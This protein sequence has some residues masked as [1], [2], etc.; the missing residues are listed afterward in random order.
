MGQ[1]VG[2]ERVRRWLTDLYQQLQLVHAGIVVA[3]STLR[4]QNSERDV[5]VA[6]VLDYFVAARVD[7]Q[8]RRAAQMITL[9]DPQSAERSPSELNADARCA[10]ADAC[11]PSVDPPAFQGVSERMLEY[12][13]RR[14]LVG[15]PGNHAS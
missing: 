5:E 9:L 6:Q 8:L 10:D 7:C 2:E 13:P 1:A 4:Y 14:G 11:N 12:A 15:S 3:S